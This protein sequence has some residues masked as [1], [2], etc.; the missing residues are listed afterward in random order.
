[1]FI[2]LLA[3]LIIMFTFAT[4]CTAVAEE[5]KSSIMS[6]MANRFSGI[7]DYTQEKLHSVTQGVKEFL[8]GNEKDTQPEK[9][10]ADQIFNKV[11][12]KF[13]NLSNEAIELAVGK[14]PRS[15]TAFEF[16]TLQEPKYVRLIRSAQDIL[17]NSQANH[18]FE[19]IEKL[20]DKN[21]EYNKKINELKRKRISAPE[22]S[23]N[24]LK[25]TRSGID[26]KI[27][28]YTNEIAHNDQEIE[29]LKNDIQAILHEEGINLSREELNYFIV[30]A[31]GDDLSNLM[32]IAENMKKIQKIIENE[33]K[34]DGNNVDL[35]KI[36]TGMYLVSLDAFSTAH[37]GVIDNIQ[38]Y[39]SKLADIKEEAHNNYKEAKRLKYGASDSDAANL[40]S[41]IKINERTLQVADMY[42]NLLTR[43][44]ENLRIS[45]KN[46]DQK[47]MLARNTYRTIVNGAALINLVN[48]GS[49]EYLTLVNFEMP[50]LKNM[51][52]DAMM[53]AF[54]DISEKI[55]LE[56]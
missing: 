53:A 51:Y 18:L 28:D 44:A 3:S 55:K 50:E 34:N 30:S 10:N 27:K 22:K 46:L 48:D 4:T 33:L 31:E 39:R 9:G 25:D 21:R 49:N 41:N 19:D 20:R 29:N 1:M 24:P 56:K 43:R 11:W 8:S 45:K 23:M 26:R 52:D 35:V 15:R 42:D 32:A 36:Y 54:S 17:S 47:V 2:K 7:T 13:A 12:D 38:K 5:K 37:E 16:V 14:N 40:E 6:D